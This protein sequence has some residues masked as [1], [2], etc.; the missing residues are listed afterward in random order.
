MECYATLAT[1]EGCNLLWHI[2]APSS[3]LSLFFCLFG[4][5]VCL[6]AWAKRGMAIRSFITIPTK[7]H[8]FLILGV[9]LRKIPLWKI[10]GSPWKE[11]KIRLEVNKFFFLPLV[12]ATLCMQII[13]QLRTVEWKKC[14][15]N[16]LIKKQAILFSK[17][18]RN[19]AKNTF[20]WKH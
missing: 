13:F 6:P 2:V 19:Q 4:L 17:K 14:A 3:L 15:T 20:I 11:G 5:N 7:A 10:V 18:H 12:M 8:K 9:C 16:Q 1:L